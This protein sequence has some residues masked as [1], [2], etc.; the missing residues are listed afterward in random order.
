MTDVSDDDFD[1]PMLYQAK[2]NPSSLRVEMGKRVGIDSDDESDGDGEHMGEDR[3]YSPMKKMKTQGDIDE[4]SVG[5]DDEY[6]VR[7]VPRAI[8]KNDAEF[9]AL[10][11]T[12]NPREDTTGGADQP[13]DAFAKA[14][15]KGKMA[16]EKASKQLSGKRLESKRLV[17]EALAK[18]RAVKGQGLGAKVE[19][20]YLEGEAKRLAKGNIAGATLSAE[21]KEKGKAALTK[22]GKNTALAKAV[23]RGKLSEKMNEQQKKEMGEAR[24]RK[25]KA[26]ALAEIKSAGAVVTDGEVVVG[27][28]GE[29]MKVG[30]GK[31]SSALQ[32]ALKKVSAKI[33][34]GD[35]R[36]RLIRLQV[37]RNLKAKAFSTL[38]SAVKESGDAEAAKANARRLITALRQKV[39]KNK[40]EAELVRILIE[41]KMIKERKPASTVVSDPAMPSAASTEEKSEEPS[42]D[43]GR[44]ELTAGNFVQIK[45]YGSQ[46]KVYFNEDELKATKKSTE[47]DAKIIE[48]LIEQIKSKYGAT[49]YPEIRRKLGDRAKAIYKKIGKQ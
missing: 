19:K 44:V 42:A 31:T 21:T 13:A 35:A 23:E 12:G 29:K 3:D 8:T 15:Q 28:K 40:E 30:V 6:G 18:A 5:S 4:H 32:S 33:E 20:Q 1:D 48:G 27:K 26:G 47:A 38:L 9:D 22:L 36:V 37:G 10:I 24:S 34:G 17:A 2:Y 39:A 46:V 25:A 49:A 14:E 43:K 41:E 16:E 7:G 45:P 11:P